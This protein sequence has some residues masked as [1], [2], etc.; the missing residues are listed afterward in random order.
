MITKNL[1]TTETSLRAGGKPF[2]SFFISPVSCFF[3]VQVRGTSFS[4]NKPEVKN[5]DN[6]ML[7]QMELQRLSEIMESEVGEAVEYWA[8]VMA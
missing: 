6:E 1:E 4:A 2:S 3:Q 7:Y 8:E 5:L